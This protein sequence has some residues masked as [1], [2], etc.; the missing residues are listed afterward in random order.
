M[1]NHDISIGEMID[2]ADEARIGL[3]GRDPEIQ[4]VRL[5]SEFNQL[6]RDLKFIAQTLAEEVETRQRRE[7]FFVCEAWEVAKKYR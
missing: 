7:S 1:K 3:L 4:F 6:R 2:A 5:A